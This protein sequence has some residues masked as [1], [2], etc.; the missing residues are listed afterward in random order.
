M[1]SLT[2]LSRCTLARCLRSNTPSSLSVSGLTLSNHYPRYNSSSAN[3]DAPSLSD[4]FGTLA[5]PIGAHGNIKGLSNRRSQ[6]P[7][8]PNRSTPTSETDTSPTPRR[9]PSPAR[10]LNPRQRRARMRRQAAT[11]VTS[12]GTIRRKASTDRSHK[13]QETSTSVDAATGNE[14]PV[15]Y[16][17]KVIEG[18]SPNSLCCCLLTDE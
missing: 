1:L 2:R 13:K 7:V 12:K 5:V 17:P 8:P 9:P 16:D 6:Q 10:S 18:T 3:G 15:E 11:K 14:T 4:V